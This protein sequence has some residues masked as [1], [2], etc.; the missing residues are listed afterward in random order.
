MLLTL[1]F[2]CKQF[3]HCLRQ[4]GL[5]S[6]TACIHI[7]MTRLHRQARLNWPQ[8]HVNWTDNSSPMSQGTVLTLQIDMLVCGEDVGSDFKMSNGGGSIMVWAGI[9]RGGR[10][11]PAH[12]DRRHDDWCTL[13]G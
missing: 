2:P 5:W 4:S 10:T 7:F 1:T 8:D 11:K 12:H 6:R 13:Q 9:T 3:R